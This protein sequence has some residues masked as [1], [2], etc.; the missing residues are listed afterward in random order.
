MNALTRA[1]MLLLAGATLCG[2]A[3][4]QE[5]R[6]DSGGGAGGDTPVTQLAVSANPVLLA[7]DSA[8]AA[9]MARFV[10]SFAA[11]FSHDFPPL[12]QLRG[13]QLH[14]AGRGVPLLRLR[15]SS[16]RQNCPD[17]GEQG[18]CQGE[19]HME[20]ALLDSG[21]DVV[22]T[23]SSWIDPEEMNAAGYDDYYKR[24]LDL[25]I[26]DRVFIPN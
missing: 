9:R 15:A 5:Y 1:A 22:W 26:K 8:E 23:F 18:S 21:G 24:L 17:K 6:I 11:R 16:Y 4:M 20:G 7:D 12:L 19:V 3:A 14:S 25:M 2:C 13:L 10:E